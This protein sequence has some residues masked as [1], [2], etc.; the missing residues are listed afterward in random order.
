MSTTRPTSDDRAPELHG[1]AKRAYELV[2]ALLEDTDGSGAP[3][4]LRG[5][6]RGPAFRAILA[7]LRGLDPEMQRAVAKAVARSGGDVA[8]LRAALAGLGTHGAI[9]RGLA[10]RPPTVVDARGGSRRTVLAILVAFVAAVGWLALTL[11][12]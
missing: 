3:A 9:A 11:A 12:Q 2:S 5:G 4:A 6:L 10:A 8:A 1:D 7:E